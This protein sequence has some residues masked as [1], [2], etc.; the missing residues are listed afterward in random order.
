MPNNQKS[1][2][3]TFQIEFFQEL[4]IFFFQNLPLLAQRVSTEFSESAH[5][6]RQ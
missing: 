6:Q 1:K 4:Q 5:F 3:T 2:I